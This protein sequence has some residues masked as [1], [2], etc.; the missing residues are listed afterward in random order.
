MWNKAVDQEVKNP[1]ELFAAAVVLFEADEYGHAAKVLKANLRKGLN[2][3]PW[4]HELL[5]VTL[6]AAG[7]ASPAELERVALSGVDLDPADPKAYLKAAK[8]EAELGRHDRAVAL[9]KR[10]AEAGPDQP[11]AYANALA[12]AKQAK[13]VTPDTVAWAASNLLGRDW[14]VSDGV[15]YHRQTKELLPAFAD[16]FGPK[17]A[18]LKDLAA[19]E[20]QRDLVIELVWTGKADLDLAVTE[21]PG[22]VCSATAKRTAAGGVLRADDLV[23]DKDGG[24]AKVY[25]AARAFSGTYT[26]AVKTAFGRPDGDTVRLKVTKFKGTPREAHDLVTVDLRANK[27]V[28]VKLDGGTRTELTAVTA[29]VT[30]VVADAPPAAGFGLTGM[31]GAAAPAGAAMA[32]PAVGSTGPALPAVVKPRE[33]VL[34]GLGSAADIRANYSLT[35]DRKS[36]NVSVRPVF[37]TAGGRDV[38]LPKVP[39][40]PGGE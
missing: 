40:L 21:P 33:Q 20:A 24:R 14:G 2:T 25:T 11:G 39:L 31:G 22:S 6:K 4:A 34:P 13:D 28:E 26:V 8:A 5:G 30:A 15:D 3:N 16:R 9:C 23:P 37:A 35:P 32:A 1:V 19:A 7:Q 36:V 18:G 27:P 29:D 17:G 38:K 12:Y 10:A